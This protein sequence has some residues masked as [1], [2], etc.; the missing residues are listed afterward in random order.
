MK[1][2]DFD[3]MGTDLAKFFALPKLFSILGPLIGA[4]LVYFVG[5]WP[6]FLIAMAGEVLSFLPLAGIKT[7]VMQITFHW[8]KSFTGLVRRRELFILECLENFIEESDW[9][10]GIYV[11][12]V[13]GSLEVPGIAGTFS[14]IGAALFTLFVGKHAVRFS[15]NIVIVSGLGLALIFLSQVFVSNSI[16]AYS[17]SLGAAFIFSAFLVSYSSVIYREVKGNN[18]EEFII[19]REIP[20][21]VAR[22]LVFGGIIFFSTKPGL[23][24]LLPMAVALVLAIRFSLRGT[25]GV[26]LK[27]S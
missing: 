3:K 4:A 19:L 1:N 7:D 10:W 15:R 12:L 23:F 6:T 14:A 25:L 13:I 22:M 5:F 20:V 24:F 16:Q 8:R 9:F 27:H 26:S 18:E 2:A 11:F 21:V 17:I